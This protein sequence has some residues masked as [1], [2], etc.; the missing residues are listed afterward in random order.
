MEHPKDKRVNSA[1]VKIYGL[2]GYP[3]KHSLSA[4]MHNAAFKHLGIDA[5]YEYRLFEAK[6]D[7][8]ESFLSGDLPIGKNLFS[9]DVIGFN[10]T[11]PHKVRALQFLQKGITPV[12]DLNVVAAGAINTVKRDGKKLY[13]RNTDKD[14]F[15]KSLIG[16]LKF[17]LENKTIFIFGAG[18]AGRAITAGLFPQVGFKVKGVYLYD[19]K[20]EAI[21]AARSHFN[22][23]GWI[24]EKIEYVSS[25]EVISEKIAQ[26]QLLVNA[27]PVGM[28]DGDPSPIDKNLL[29][30]DLYVYDV[31]YNRT[32][33]LVKDAQEK[34][35]AACGGTGMLLYQGV[36]AFN[37]WM[38]PEYEAPVEVMRKALR[39]AIKAR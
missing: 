12:S 16:D 17:N 26:C 27:S 29:R 37:F 38:K 7:D 5:E 25:S 13:Y 39:A 28:K 15:I 23:F 8:L 4:I 14:G 34:C 18:G 3:V 33:Q 11:I 30:K 32:T 19:I 35:R 9:R 1:F 10:I 20:K 2:I 36:D 21:E 31:V 22:N 6:P 24:K